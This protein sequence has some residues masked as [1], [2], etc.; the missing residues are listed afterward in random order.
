MLRSLSRPGSS[1]PHALPQSVSM[2]A[3]L[4]CTGC[5]MSCV[6]GEAE[7]ESIQPPLSK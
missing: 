6:S 3:A 4:V 2:G 1:C 7:L 5:A